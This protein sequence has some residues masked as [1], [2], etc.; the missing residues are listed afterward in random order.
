MSVDEHGVIVFCLQPWFNL[1]VEVAEEG[2][3]ISIPL[4]FKK[5]LHSVAM[6]MQVTAFVLQCF[7]TMS[8]VKFVLLLDNHFP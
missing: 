3:D 6:S 8:G 7:V 5:A 1:A 2:A 4:D